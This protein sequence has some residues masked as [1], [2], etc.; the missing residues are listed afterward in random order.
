MP[1]APPDLSV[2]VPL[3]DEEQV[4]PSFVAALEPVLDRLEL[5]WELVLVDD[6]S[7]D[8]TARV[9]RELAGDR[10][11]PLFLARNFGKEAAMA[12]GLEAATGRGVLLMDGD[13]QHPVEAIPAFVDAW[14]GGADVV[15]GVKVDRGREGL[16]Y[17][18]FAGLFNRLM[19]LALDHDF[20]RQS[21][22]KLLDRGVV[23]VIVGLPERTRFFRG[24]V[25]WVGFETAEVPFTVQARHAGRTS[26]SGWGLVLYSLRN[27]VAFT[28]VPLR[29]VAA[30]GFLCTAFGALLGVDTFVNWQQ[31]RAVDGFTTTIL[32]VLIMGGVNLIALGIMSLY[33]SAIFEEVK[34][35]PLFVVR[36]RNESDSH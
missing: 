22:F 31:G 5:D 18:L 23:D 7:V 17:G 12:A 1:T 33:L 32:S 30:M 21:D 36:A 13:L 27:L 24:L 4:L 35:R 10:V 15:N 16:V 3:H 28:S 34:R 25:A 29:L 8:G 6:G 9:M 14:R 26:W 20:V 19:G 11:I 2:V